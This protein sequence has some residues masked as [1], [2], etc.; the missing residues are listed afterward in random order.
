M[1]SLRNFGVCQSVYLFKSHILRPTFKLQ[2]QRYQ[3]KYFLLIIPKMI[4][5]EEA[6]QRQV[7]DWFDKFVYFG[8][9]LVVVL[10]LY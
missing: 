2:I 8:S 9:L 4:T 5:I 10:F 7:K 1:V 3:F 6:N